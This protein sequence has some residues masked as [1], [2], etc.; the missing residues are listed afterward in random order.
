MKK[1]V[2]LLA[3][4][5]L[6]A[7][8]A[9]AQ[10]E[11]PDSFGLYW[12]T[13]ADGCYMMNNM[14]GPAGAAT[15]HMVI[16]GPSAGSCGGLEVVFAL[17]EGAGAITGTTFVV[18]A[19]DVDGRPEGVAA[20]FAE[21]VFASG[22]CGMIYLGTLNMFAF[23]SPTNIFAGPNDPATIPGKPSYLDGENV[24]IVIPLNFSVDMDGMGTG[25][26]GWLLP[27]YPL[28]AYNGD[29]PVA[30]EE[31]TWTGVKGLFR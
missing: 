9:M 22:D 26:D 28:A 7:G 11:G 21:P 17:N 29:A 6:M 12:D 14:E 19:V 1:L 15:A 31:A 10:D 4:A 25:D 23:G 24:E 2:V 27:D 8:S 13:P 5:G 3:V 18:S 20:G 16:A 30:T